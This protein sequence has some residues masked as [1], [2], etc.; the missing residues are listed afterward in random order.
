MATLTRPSFY[1]ADAE[2]AHD[3]RVALEVAYKALAEGLSEESDVEEL[4]QDLDDV[5]W[6]SLL[7]SI[8]PIVVSWDDEP[9]QGQRELVESCL[10]AG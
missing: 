1:E 10:I 6:D 3:R 5:D 7:C 4:E 9:M 2:K 8:G